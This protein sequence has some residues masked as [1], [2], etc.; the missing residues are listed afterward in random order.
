MHDT[1]YRGVKNPF[2]SKTVLVIIINNPDGDNARS[3]FSVTFRNARPS[4][5][6]LT[7]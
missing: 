3:S 6:G 4:L 2:T 7:H 5:S 1:R